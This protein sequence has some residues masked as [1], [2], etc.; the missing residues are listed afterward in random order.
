KTPFISEGT[1]GVVNEMLVQMQSFDALTGWQRVHGWFVDR[2]NLFLA[3]DR[4]LNRP[5]A[6]PTNVLLIA[7][8]NRADSLDPALLRPGRFDRRLTFELPAKEGRRK[9]LDHYL[10]RKSHADELDTDDKRD[11]L[12]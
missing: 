3:P 8:T 10:E 6:I 7:A 9:L 1:G 11:A 2:V 12:A 4:Q 5:K